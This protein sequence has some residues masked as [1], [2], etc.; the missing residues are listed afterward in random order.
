MGKLYDQGFNSGFAEILFTKEGAT[1]GLSGTA[2]TNNE[3]SKYIEI[4]D[5]ADLEKVTGASGTQQI[6]IVGIN[7]SINGGGYIGLWDHDAVTGGAFSAHFFISGNGSWG[8][9]AHHVGFANVKP[10]AAK[11]IRLISGGAIEAYT[12]I[13][14]VKKD[15]GFGNIQT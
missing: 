3:A 1:T 15:A 6:S 7:W 8:V 12:V 14:K 10:S 13:L 9:G 11:G 2:F 4:F 5:L